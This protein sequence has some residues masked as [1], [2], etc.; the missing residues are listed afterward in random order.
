MYKNLRL[1]IFDCSTCIYMCNSYF[2]VM[3]SRHEVWSKYMILNW[4]LKVLEVCNASVGCIF[5]CA[6]KW[7][8][9]WKFHLLKGS[10]TGSYVTNTKH[11]LSQPKTLN[12]SG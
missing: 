5:K 11:N 4:L 12:P 1:L 6:T 7:Q 10:V 2:T 8:Y 9:L 3:K